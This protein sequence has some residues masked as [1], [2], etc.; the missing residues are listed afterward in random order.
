MRSARG[1]IR[2]CLTAEPRNFP[3]CVDDKHAVT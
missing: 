3:G 2:I 1:L